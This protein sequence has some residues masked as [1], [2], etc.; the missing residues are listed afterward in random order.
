MTRQGTRREKP[1]K[2]L[3]RYPHS[4]KVEGLSRR[5]LSRDE[6]EEDKVI[7]KGWA[8]MALPLQ[9]FNVVEVRKPNVGQNKPASVKADILLDTK[10]MS[11]PVL[12]CGVR[13]CAFL[14]LGWSS[15][16]VS[17]VAGVRKAMWANVSQH[18]SRQ[19]SCRQTPH[20]PPAI[21]NPCTLDTV[22]CVGCDLFCADPL[23]PA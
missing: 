20:V 14:R 5:M 13:A 6:N 21:Q 2:A 17:S 23:E 9:A 10:R 8:R 19:T 7:F 18:V 16:Y 11:L 1:C 3:R 15:I 22:R 4:D 12:S